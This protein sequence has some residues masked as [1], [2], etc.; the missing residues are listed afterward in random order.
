LQSLAYAYYPTNNV[1]TITNA[2]NSGSGQ[3]I[4]SAPPNYGYRSGSDQLA[5]LSVGGVVTQSIGYAADGKMANLN[6]GIQ[7]KLQEGESC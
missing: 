1:Q 2:V 7:F 5:T 3:N 6:P 4:G